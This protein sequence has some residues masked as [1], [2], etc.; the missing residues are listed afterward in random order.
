M[1]PHKPRAYGTTLKRTSRHP[2]S[3]QARRLATRFSSDKQPQSRGES[4]KK[5]KLEH[6]ALDESQSISFIAPSTIYIQFSWSE[7]AQLFVLAESVLILLC[8]SINQQLERQI[9][10]LGRDLETDAGTAA[11]K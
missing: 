9:W 6:G 8:S 10:A 5:D 7:R 1:D 4:I 3:R 11:A 2:S